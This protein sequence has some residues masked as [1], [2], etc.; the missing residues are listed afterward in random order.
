M[1]NGITFTVRY[2]IRLKTNIDYYDV[3]LPI[4]SVNRKM[5]ELIVLNGQPLLVI[6]GEKDL[7]PRFINNPMNREYTK[8]MYSINDVGDKE[9]TDL[10]YEKDNIKY[11]QAFLYS[12]RLK[13]W[14]NEQFIPDKIYNEN[15]IMELK[16]KGNNLL[17]TRR[18][19]GYDDKYWEVSQEITRIK[20]IIKINP[21][22]SPNTKQE[23]ISLEREI[24]TIELTEEELKI[25]E[26]VKLSPQIADNI[27]AEGFQLYECH[28]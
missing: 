13:I 18:I 1:V 17:E 7:H 2:V 16:E 9:L 28:W 21:I 8:L 11:W 3:L 15:E 5:F 10:K 24:S 4:C 27:L 26:R 23:I 6:F 22:F 19:L 14:V 25:L 20:H 12:S